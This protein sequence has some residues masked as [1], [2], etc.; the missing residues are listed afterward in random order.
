MP[1]TVLIIVILAGIILYLSFI[2]R[3]Y[4]FPKKISQI[5]HMIELNNTKPAIKLLKSIIAKNERNALAHWYLGEAYYKEKR[6]ELA[7]VEYK[8]VIK[9]AIFQKNYQR[10]KLEKD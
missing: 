9:L 7:I 4:I 10:L 2:F 6:Y 5:A 3:A 8:F 1:L